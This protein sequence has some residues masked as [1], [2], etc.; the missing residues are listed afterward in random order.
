MSTEMSYTVKQ[1][2]RIAGVSARTLHYYDEIDLLK[3]DRNPGNGYRLYT[4]EAVLRL[5][6]ILF[7]RELGLGL[8]D[9]RSVLEQPG[10]DLLEALEQHRTAL[11]ERQL[12]LEQLIHTVERTI[13]HLKGNVEMDSKELFEGFSE[14]EEKQY[15][16][17]ARRR[18]GDV[19]VDESMRRWGSYSKE[20]KQAVLAEG[21][22]IYKDIIALLDHDPKSPEVQAC[23]TRWH[24]NLR[25][26]YDPTP[27]I[28]RG[29]GDLY[30]DDPQFNATFVKMH[31]DLA[32]FMRKAIRY[33]VE[34]L[35]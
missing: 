23:I 1:L 6:Q 27:E 32:P 29:L 5:Q 3:P 14:E 20:E 21:G 26:F 34:Q 19:N 24:Q 15:A 30:N 18:W 12:R 8:E 25:S 11:I 35:K 9:I 17:E 33:Y 7:L 4:R 22:A 31:P 13:N 2:A 10:F 28:L 16:E